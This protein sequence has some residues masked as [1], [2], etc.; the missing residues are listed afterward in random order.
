MVSIPK[1][2]T[3]TAWSTL[4]ALR[5][6]RHIFSALEVLHEQLG[7]VFQLPL[8]GFRSVVL[9]GPEANR[10]LLVES[11]E[12]LRWRAER[13]PVTRLL[14]QG[15]LVTDGTFHD[16]LRQTMNPSLHRT[17]FEGYLQAMWQ[18]TDRVSGAW[19]EGARI[20]MLAEMRRIALLIL[21]DTLFGEDFGPHVNT[22][23]PAVLRTI[24]YISP[25]P[26]L[27]RPGIPRLGYRRA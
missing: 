25:G 15:V 4:R 27:L 11:R 19:G 13:D 6:D 1:P 20:D 9:V 14:R 5:R 17:M 7:D 26:W 10:F 12:S 16:E 22:L 2:D 23:L 21:T 3:A 24:R 18:A 8:P